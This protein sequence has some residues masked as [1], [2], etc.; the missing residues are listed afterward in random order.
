MRL[1]AVDTTTARGSLALLDE[2]T[3]AG[4]VRTTEAEGHSRWLL[5]AL[6]SLL[7]SRRWRLEDLAGFAVTVGPGSFTGLRVGIATVQGLALG[8][9]KPCVG[10]IALDVLASLASDQRGPVVALMDAWRDEVYARVYEDG[11][12][13]GEPFSCPVAGLRGRVDPRA[14]LLGDG[15]LRYG[16]RLRAALPEARFLQADLFLAVPL[17]RLA[18]GALRVGGGTG[19]EVLKPLY[20]RDV[21]IRPAMGPSAADVR[22]KP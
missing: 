3:V 7:A 1:L 4:E 20:V 18:L 12:P 21:D 19:P 11:R 8:A 15:A 16:E 22:R 2:E 9:A 10:V 13:T 5:P 17:G 14:T 6:E